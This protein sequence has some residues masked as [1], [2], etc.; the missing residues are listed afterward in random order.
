MAAD[1]HKS[2]PQTDKN[3]MINHPNHLLSF[4]E[5]KEV[6]DGIKVFLLYLK[7]LGRQ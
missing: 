1:D 2:K 3:K 4:Q 6:K 5:C 7:L